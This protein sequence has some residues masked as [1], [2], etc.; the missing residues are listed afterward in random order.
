M[1]VA[2]M[3]L[4]ALGKP[5]AANLL[6]AGFDTTVWNRTAS[7]GDA[8]VQQGAHQAAEPVEA[9]QCDVFLSLLFDDDAVEDIF[10]NRGL[11]AQAKP[12]ALHVCMSTI[13]TALV[14]RLMEAH[15]AH[16]VGYV[17][18]PVLGRPEAAAAAQLNILAAGASE[19]LTSLAL[20]FAALGRTWPMGEDP[21]QG[22]LAKIAANFLLISAGESMLEAAQLIRAHGGNPSPLLSM[23]S[24]TLLASPIYR[25]LAQMMSAPGLVR[26]AEANRIPLKDIGLAVAEGAA[27]AT[28]LPFGDVMLKRLS[29]ALG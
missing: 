15:A 4:G 11:L 18:A 14:S 25:G 17:G 19:H 26:T 6:K 21:R 16:G 20:V 29:G 27:K 23:M 9:M 2:V 3:G 24:E 7:A 22:H 12:G 8:L 10:L 28:P 5:I 13:S 1:K